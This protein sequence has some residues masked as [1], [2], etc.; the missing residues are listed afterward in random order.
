MNY[1]RPSQALQRTPREQFDGDERTIKVTGEAS[2]S[3][4]P[5]QVTII[6]GVR[7]ENQSS[8]QAQQ[9]NAQVINQIKQA[10]Y[11]LNIPQQS[12][13]TFS[14]QMTAQYD[15]VDGKQV[16]R[17]Y[18]VTHL[19]QIQLAILSMAGQVI[20]QAVAA[21]ANEVVSVQYTLRNREAAVNQ[22]LV[23]A[24][25]NAEEKAMAIA[26]SL[27]VQIQAVPL[28]VEEI[29]SEGPVLYQQS[30]TFAVGGGTQLEPGLLTIQARLN[31]LFLI[32]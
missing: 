12:I 4:A 22:A 14:Y 26:G 5:D 28:K 7:T 16:F 31:T 18:E 9:E 20:D 27:S 30:M 1:Y 29:L 6:L 10:L 3:V 15:Y 11:Q 8:N 24:M 25:Q 2:I 13:Q 23:L 17:A 32:T 21:G 19:L